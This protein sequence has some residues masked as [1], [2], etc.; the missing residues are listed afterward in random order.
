[1]E[2]YEFKDLDL[3]EKAKLIMRLG[4]LVDRR[5]YIN[6]SVILYSLST[7]FIEMFYN[8][9]TNDFINISVADDNDLRKYLTDINLDFT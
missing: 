2:E 7:I 6:V 4:K 1:M 8:K 5:D 9:R 3:D